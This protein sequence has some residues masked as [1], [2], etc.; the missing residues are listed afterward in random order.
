VLREELSPTSFSGLVHETRI[1]GLH[2]LPAGPPTQA[3]AH[4]LYSPN[5]AAVLDRFR[6]DYDVI[7]VD[8]PPMLQ[9]TDARVTARLADAVVLVA[10]SGKTTRDALLAARDRLYE[11]RIEV[12]GTILN[13]WNPRRAVESYYGYSAVEAY[14]LEA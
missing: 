13:G 14:K 12:L 2:V 10:R 6:S 1:P 11:D 4:L 5:L 7:F 8:T 9:M 3:A